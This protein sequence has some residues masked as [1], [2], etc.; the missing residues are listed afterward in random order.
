T[1]LSVMPT[2]DR[3]PEFRKHL[4]SNY[5]RALNRLPDG[6]DLSAARQLTELSGV[7][8]YACI[9]RR[10]TAP[11]LALVGDAAMTSDY[12]WGTGCSFAFQTAEWLVDATAGAL[13]SGAA[14]DPGLER[15]RQR[16]HRTLAG[17]QRL[18]S[19]FATG[20]PFNAMERLIFS[21]A[22]R[23]P[24]VGRH[25]GAFGERRISV[26]QFLAPA[27]LLRSALVNS[28]PAAWPA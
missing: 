28:R 20:R 1:I 14:V 5:F 24:I 12:L 7:L 25:V 23:D 17:H 4:S 3:L 22:V 21:A 2:K 10:P 19:D 15:Y 16:H 6:P 11:G 27:M 26:K 9:S 13:L 18:M 8:N